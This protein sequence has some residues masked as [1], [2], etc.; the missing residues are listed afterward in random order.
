[1]KIPRWGWAGIVM[2]LGGALVPAA[3]GEAVAGWVEEY[4]RFAAQ[5]NLEPDR[6]YARRA[7]KPQRWLGDVLRALP[8]PAQWPELR[9]ALEQAAAGLPEGRE[10]RQA[11]TGAWLLA[12]L[13]G[14]R[15]AVEAGLAAAAAAAGNDPRA[16]FAFA[17]LRES[18][19]GRTA[20]APPLAQRVRQF[21]EQLQALEPVDEAAVIRELGGPENLARLRRLMAAGAELQ[22]QFFAAY[23]EY[24]KTKDEAA[25]RAKIEALQKDFMAAN[26]AD[27]EALAPYFERPLVGRY[28]AAQRSEQADGNHVPELSLPDLVAH[29]GEAP[30]AALLRRALALPV[31][32][33]VNRDTGEATARLARALALELAGQVKFPS[34][35]LTHDVRSTALFE[36]LLARF[37]DRGADD[38]EFEAACGYYLAGLIQQERVADAVAFATRPGAGTKLSLPYEGLN[39]LEQGGRAEALWEFLRGWLQQV[40]AAN[41]WDRFNRLSAQLG[42]QAEL[43]ALVKAM[44]E[45]GRFEGLDRLR[46]QRMQA[47]AELAAGE[48]AEAVARLRRLVRETAATKEEKALQI[49]QAIRLLALADLRGDRPGADEALATAEA[50]IAAAWAE[51][52]SGAVDHRASLVSTLNQAGRRADAERIGR[53]TLADVTARRQAARQAEGEAG[54]RDDIAGYALERLLAEQLRVLVELERWADARELILGSPLWDVRDAA[55]LLRETVGSNRRPVGFYL[56]QVARQAG[57]EAR[58][59]RLLEAQLVAAPGADAVYAAYLEMTGQKARPLLAR[60]AAADRYEERPLIWLARLQLDAGEVDA[61][62]ATLQQAIAVDPSDG[63]Q[64]RG[65]R[66][67]VY[68][69]MAQAMAAKG[70]AEKARFFEGVVKAIRLSEDADRWYD[71]GAYDQAIAMYRESLGFFQDAYCI[72]SRLAVRLAHEGRMDEAAEHYRRAFE[73]MPDSFGR[74]E[75]HCFGC[76]HVFAGEKSQGVA[77]RVFA[78]MLQAR[79][80]RPQLHYLMGYL[81]QEQERLPEAAEYYRAA[82]KLDPLYLNAWK[83]LA[84]LDRQVTFS[85]QERDDLQLKL[86]ELDPGRRHASPDLERV[87]DIPRLWSALRAAERTLADL[88]PTE[89]LWPLTASAAWLEAIPAAELPWKYDPRPKDAAAILLEH[90]FVQGLQAYLGALNARAEEG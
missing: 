59:R 17:Q 71:L 87:G 48:L 90:P 88:P 89:E 36:A 61:A 7:G 20:D 22:R 6:V 30:A 78:Q 60:L 51:A 42:R 39:A 23:T 76:E 31:R 32:L 63:E 12:Y 35:G 65:D 9:A 50:L 84:G 24:E 55:D 19:G 58:A 8:E 47:D 79:P 44:A 11:Q 16:E 54:E 81:R 40:P 73:L 43:K 46:V 38:Y 80:E 21:E 56:A 26:A 52:P 86:L 14:D 18:L 70:D 28:L 62:V 75:S 15:A 41:E 1:M 53:Q 72:Q 74:V 77:E 67:R 45:A 2:L 82:V 34:W 57:D 27:E 83:R 29:A 85:A 33:G 37:P 49:E 10:R 69:F 66:M 64:G 4:R 3:A 5:E 25:A 13:T 68:A